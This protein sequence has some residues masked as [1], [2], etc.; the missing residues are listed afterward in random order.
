MSRSSKS[1]IRP[2]SPAQLRRIWATAK[3][4]DLREE[5]LR[6][7]VEAMTGKRTISGLSF[8]NAILVIRELDGMVTE[9]RRAHK[10]V[11]APSERANAGQVKYLR[12][13]AAKAGWDEWA[14]RSWLRRWFKAS[15]EQWLDNKH[16]TKAITALKAMVSRQA[17]EQ[18]AN[19]T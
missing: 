2:K 16:A 10:R 5:N 8:R 13:L 19:G 18:E 11:G 3:R 9:R 7:L 6:D 1:S 12:D 15:H 17:R 4:L 14:L